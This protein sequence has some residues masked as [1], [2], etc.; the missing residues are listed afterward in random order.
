[1]DRP[2]M[3]ALIS[4]SFINRKQWAGVIPRCDLGRLLPELVDLTRPCSTLVQ[5]FHAKSCA[6]DAN[7]PVAVEAPG[8]LG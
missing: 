4:N 3:P 1:M 5:A 6:N 8:F 7:T 2:D